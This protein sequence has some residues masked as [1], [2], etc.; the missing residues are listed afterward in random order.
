MRSELQKYTKTKTS[1]PTRLRKG[2][3]MKLNRRSL[4]RA[5]TGTLLLSAWNTSTLFGQEVKEV[6]IS[7]ANFNWSNWIIAKGSF[8]Y[9]P[10]ADAFE[11]HIKARSL[12]SNHT[13][14]LQLIAFDPVGGRVVEKFPLTTDSSGSVEISART[15]RVAEAD[16]PMFQVHVFV[17][18]PDENDA[19]KTPPK[20]TGVTHGA[21]LVCQYPAGFRLQ[22]QK[23]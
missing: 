7:L 17:V 20:V 12:R 5:S 9:R 19:P 8:S 15:E 21:P 3:T 23:S 13:Y 2:V 14:E 18:D 1:N 16:M 11:V 6:T 4:L 22:Q 10:V